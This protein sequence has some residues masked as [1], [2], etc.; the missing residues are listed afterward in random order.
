MADH[1]LRIMLQLI[2]N[3]ALAT[4]L[5]KA[6]ISISAKNHTRETA[7][8]SDLRIIRKPRMPLYR[9]HKPA[10]QKNQISVNTLRKPTSDTYAKN[11]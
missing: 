1:I 8:P 9:R 2:C 7:A 5:R 3:I 11:G 10:R 6:L 4:V